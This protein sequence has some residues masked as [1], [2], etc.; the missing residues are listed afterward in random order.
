MSE[1]TDITEFLKN[2][3][4]SNS[5]GNPNPT[6]TY[7][8]QPTNKN[9]LQVI[10]ISFLIFFLFWLIAKFIYE[11]FKNLAKTKSDKDGTAKI[12]IRYYEIAN[13]IYYVTIFIGFSIA[14]SNIGLET[15]TL[16]TL[17]GTFGL[18]LSLS[19][20]SSL[21]N[22][23]SGIII[24][25]NDLY[26][27]GDIIE[28]QSQQGNVKGTV[29]D[30]TLF[31]TILSDINTGKEIIIPNNILQSNIIVN[32]SNIYTPDN[33]SGNMNMKNN[34]NLKFKHVSQN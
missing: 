28:L 8:L 6:Y 1:K 23:T 30:F 22:F 5:K 31:S 10:M 20:Q 17:L 4:K 3:I 25:F 34:L 32:G 2:F 29:R 14:L 21:S 16:I 18:A 13:V 33:G 19:L 7:S 15:T 9:Y 27:I 26:Q 11:Y 12:D 24:S